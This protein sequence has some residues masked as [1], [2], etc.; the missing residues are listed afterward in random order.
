MEMALVEEYSIQRT[1]IAGNP[2][3]CTIFKIGNT[4]HCVVASESPETHVARAAGPTPD[5]ALLTATEAAKR[6]FSYG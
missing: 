3:R 4:Y 5:A 6:Q 1:V 2:V